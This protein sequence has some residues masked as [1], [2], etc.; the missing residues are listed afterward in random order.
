MPKEIIA[1]DSQRLNMTQMCAYKYHLTFNGDLVPA[2]KE[3]P[4]ER[5]SLVHQMLETYYTLHKYRARWP[6]HFDAKRMIKI[7]LTIGDWMAA[8]MDLPMEE[9]EDNFRTLEQ[10]VNFYW[11][12]PFE[13][14][15]VEQVGSR[16]LY[17]DSNI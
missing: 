15:A 10:Y 5:G 14:L 7:C 8:K 12:E 1:L 9:I 4:Y 11:N 13:T 6:K 2:F 3:A 16:I 17:E